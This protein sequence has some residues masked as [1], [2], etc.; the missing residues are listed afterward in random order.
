MDSSF[1]DIRSIPYQFVAGEVSQEP[2]AYWKFDEASWSGVTG[3]VLDETGNYNGTANGA[4]ITTSGKF[5]NAGSF[6]GTNDFI[7][8][9]STLSP[10]GDMTI[11]AWAMSYGVTKSSSWYND[12]IITKGNDLAGTTNSWGLHFSTAEDGSPIGCSFMLVTD[13]EL[14]WV[15]VPYGSIE[16][17]QWYFITGVVKA[18]TAYL[19]IDGVL[20]S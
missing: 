19:Y 8:I 12:Y 10:S 18:D 6:D 9:A 2:I 7:N 5:D 14:T 11:S 3:E 20:S 13:Q 16:K 15:T 17:N 4:V 1:N